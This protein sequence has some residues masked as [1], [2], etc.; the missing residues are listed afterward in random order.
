MGGNTFPEFFSRAPVLR[1]YDPLAA[2]LGAAEGGVIE[3][4]YADAVR[5]CGHS[6]PT[7]A[8]A[9]L[10][11][12]EGLRA[13]YG[14][15]MPERGNIEVQMRGGREEGTT[16]VTAAVA[17][18]LTGAAAETGFGGVGPQGRFSRRHLLSF[19]GGGTA[20]LRLRRRDTGRAVDVSFDGSAAPFADE[21]K[22]LM[23]KAVGGTAGP[24]ELRRF[25]ELWQARV[26]AF[27]EGCDGR[28]V[29]VEAV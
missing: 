21:M 20:V 14:G 18:L 10:M 27:L 9:Y 26:R 19:D 22:L 24:E 2:F 25:G 17:A 8:A 5:L 11:V 7:V 15:A 29:R 23:P 1:V 6:C 3:Y 4:T 13:L 12:V 28:L 16:G